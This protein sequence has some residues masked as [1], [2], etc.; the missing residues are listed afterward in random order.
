[1][2]QLQKTIDQTLLRKGQQLIDGTL[3]EEQLNKE[4][5]ETDL[6]YHYLTRL[7]IVCSDIDIAPYCPK[8]LTKVFTKNCY[9]SEYGCT[10]ENVTTALRLRKEQIMLQ[11]YMASIGENIIDFIEELNET[12]TLQDIR[13][14]IRTRYG[15]VPE[16]DL[17]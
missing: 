3:L 17:P 6:Y 16:I 4:F 11:N 15:I 12:P 10:L 2:K 1:M 14:S 9:D 7:F 5:S 13:N 8:M